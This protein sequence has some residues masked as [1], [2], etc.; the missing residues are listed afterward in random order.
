L[1]RAPVCSTLGVVTLPIELPLLRLEHRVLLPGLKV[2]LPINAKLLPAIERAWRDNEKKLV[3]V[4][5]YPDGI[6]PIGTTCQLMQR[7][8][9]LE[10]E[11]AWMVAESRVRIHFA[12]GDTANIEHYADTKTD[13]TA[14]E[15]DRARAVLMAYASGGHRVPSEIVERVAL[16]DDP[17]IVANLVLTFTNAPLSTL[18]RALELTDARARLALCVAV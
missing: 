11:R 15:L 6:A 1:H 16:S 14:E 7:D 8:A 13:V 2:S 17:E 12:R 10:G 5:A 3:T 9:D 4:Y 18:Q